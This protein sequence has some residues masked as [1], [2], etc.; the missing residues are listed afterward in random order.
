MF[1]GR[2]RWGKPLRSMDEELDL[3]RH[4]SRGYFG[5]NFFPVWHV[6]HKTSKI[7]T[8]K[9]KYLYF[10]F[11]HFVCRC[12][13]F[14]FFLWTCLASQCETPPHHQT[15]NQLSMHENDN[16]LSFFFFF[17]GGG[18]IFRDDFPPWGTESDGGGGKGLTSG[19][20]SDEEKT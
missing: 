5:D 4:T 14:F 20:E 8:M 17:M 13:S 10:F 11:N 15:S 12:W 18:L 1:K 9:L 2:R 7:W 6:F 19:T 3:I 16:T